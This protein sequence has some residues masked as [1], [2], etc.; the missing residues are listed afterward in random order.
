MDITTTMVGG[1]C[2]VTREGLWPQPRDEEIDIRSAKTLEEV[3]SLPHSPV[4]KAGTRC[5]CVCTHARVRV[6]YG[7]GLCGLL[8]PAMGGAAKG[9]RDAL[10]V[11][12]IIRVNQSLR[13][14][15]QTG[16]SSPSL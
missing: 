10:R 13:K 16:H 5:V 6:C 12:N 3:K 11:E 7:H 2:A 8:G 14:Q 1:A 15:E 4:Q 9:C